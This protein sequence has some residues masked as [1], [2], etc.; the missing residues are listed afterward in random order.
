VVALLL[1]AHRSDNLNKT[2]LSLIGIC[3]IGTIAS[4]IVTSGFRP[5]NLSAPLTK[6][7]QKTTVGNLGEVIVDVGTDKFISGIKAAIKQC[8]I[9]PGAPF[10]GLYNI[11]GV[12]VALQAVPVLTPWLNNKAQAEFVLERGRPE[13]TQSALVALQMRGEGVFPPLPRQLANFPVGYRYCG[14]AIYPDWQKK[15]QI[16]QALAR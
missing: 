8:D 7:D 4:Q 16:W 6:Q 5:Y 10:I 15:I 3:F 1:V 12:A 2:F 9:A 14:M 11:P 13:E